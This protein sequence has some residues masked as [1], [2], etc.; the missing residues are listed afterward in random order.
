MKTTESSWKNARNVNIFVREWAPDGETRAAVGLIHGLGE[1]T[2]RYQQAA[3]RLTAAG[4]ALMGPDL[5][6][7]GRSGGPRGFTSFDEI[8][9]EIDHLLTEIRQRY[10]EKPVFLYGHSMGGA[11]VLDYVLRRR[12]ALRGAIV[13][14]PGLAAGESVAAAK[15]FLAKVMARVMP[16]FSMSNGLDRNNL[17]HD[18][19]V[20]EAYQRDPLVHDRISA[21]LGFDILTRGEGLIEQA[22]DFPVPLL[23][24]QGSADH[25]VSAAAVSR[26][27]AA[28]PPDKLTFQMWE[29]L[30]HE[31]HNEP[32]NEQVFQTILNWLDQQLEVVY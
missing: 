3:G 22:K 30:Y 25:I 12:P 31:L 15:V 18:Q 32:Q 7:H 24:M 14:S 29:G 5:P 1:H 6:G 4:Y 23:L 27:A 21:R 17:S 26:F 9:G 13:T 19:A 16:A 11:A 28:V 20:I 8:S 10:P 2:G